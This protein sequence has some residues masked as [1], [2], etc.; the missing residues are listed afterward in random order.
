MFQTIL[1]YLSLCN[2]PLFFTFLWLYLVLGWWYSLSR[3]TSGGGRRSWKW[4]L[5]SG[6]IGRQVYSRARGEPLSVLIFIRRR[7]VYLRARGE[8]L[9]VLLF[10]PRR[11]VY[12]RVRSEVPSFHCEALDILCVRGSGSC[13]CLCTPNFFVRTVP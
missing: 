12:L 4:G 6:S 7:Q 13:T 9:S 2:F 5:L 8:P 1:L 11:Q 10:I 3:K